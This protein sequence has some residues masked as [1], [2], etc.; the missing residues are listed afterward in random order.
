MVFGSHERIL[1]MDGDYIYVCVQ[2]F[3]SLCHPA[4]KTQL[5]SGFCRLSFLVFLSFRVEERLK[6]WLASQSPSELLTPR[7]VEA[8]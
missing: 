3:L 6:G 7:R 1:A 5:V 2:L 8:P 4:V